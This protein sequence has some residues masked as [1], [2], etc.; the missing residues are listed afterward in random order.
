MCF[1]FPLGRSSFLFYEGMQT[2]TA[3]V[4]ALLFVSGSEII[5]FA[6]QRERRQPSLGR[7][8][9]DLSG[10]VL[11]RYLFVDLDSIFF[12]ETCIATVT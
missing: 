8:S 2:R 12:A 4:L 9:S 6:L 5:R 11:W 7:L 10:I 3:N 1:V